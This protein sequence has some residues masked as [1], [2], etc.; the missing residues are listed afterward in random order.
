MLVDNIFLLFFYDISLI[1]HELL[2]GMQMVGVIFMTIFN[3]FLH[4]Q[5]IGNNVYT[6]YFATKS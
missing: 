3:V 2:H 1:H 6:Y 4:H 5:L